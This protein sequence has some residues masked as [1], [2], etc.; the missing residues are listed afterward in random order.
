M[1]TS[2]QGVTGWGRIQGTPAGAPVTLRLLRSTGSVHQRSTSHVIAYLALTGSLLALGIDIIIPAFD[3]MRPDL[4]LD[5][6]SNDITLVITA[7][8]LGM[9]IGQPLWGPIA[10]RFGRAPAMTAGLGLYSLVALASAM[11][12]T[13]GV[14][15]VARFVWGLG[16]AAPALLRSAIARDLYT[17][18][19]MARVMSI[20]MAVFMV[21]PVAAPLLGAALLAVAPWPSVFL[22]CAVAAV[23]V[24]GWTRRFGETL[25]E[26]NR[27][28]LKFGPTIAAFRTVVS[29]RA[30]VVPA[31]ALVFNQ[32]TFFIFLGSGQPI[33]DVIFEREELF[34][35]VFSVS[36]LFL[37]TGFVVSDRLMARFGAARVLEASA[38]AFVAVALVNLMVVF[39]A[40]GRPDWWVWAV[41]VGVMNLVAVPFG[42]AVFSIALEPMGAQAGTASGVIGLMTMAGGSLLAAVFDARIVDTVS[43]MAV[44]YLGY[45]LISAALVWVGRP[46]VRA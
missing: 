41:G 5:P 35:W 3:E 32:A 1:V 6:A 23:L 25:S 26:Q 34:V 20:V 44:A 31:L 27:R 21:G 22:V 19:Q 18:D 15:L 42:P 7:Y 8:F 10:D 46:G 28:P 43:P 13:L 40:D 37:A 30:T 17:G 12:P 38:M 11:S 9:A 2:L 39:A 24:L 14:M 4:G 29:T 45:G 33:M 36:G 16:A